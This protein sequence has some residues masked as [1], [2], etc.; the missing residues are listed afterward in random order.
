MPEINFEIRSLPVHSEV[1]VAYV[2][3]N[4]H[5]IQWILAEAPSASQRETSWS[6]NA[7][8]CSPARQAVAGRERERAALA[9]VDFAPI[10]D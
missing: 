7:P 9:A 10:L 1:M 4:R 8:A 5:F 6:A 3:H 2:H